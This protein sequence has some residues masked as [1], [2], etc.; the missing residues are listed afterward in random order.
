MTESELKLERKQEECASLMELWRQCIDGF[1][2]HTRQFMLWL[3]LHTF[4][5]AIHGVE[6]T[7]K[8]YASLNRNMTPEFLVRFA[9]KVMNTAKSAAIADER[10]QKRTKGSGD[11][12]TRAEF[13]A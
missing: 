5:H 10:T 12:V 2:P 4:A 8:K 13:L 3:H 1:C 9:S 6:V 7:A 11:R